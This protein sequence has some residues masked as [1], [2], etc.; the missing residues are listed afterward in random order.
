MPHFIRSIVS[1]SPLLLFDET[2]H[3]ASLVGEL[4]SGE[5]KTYQFNQYLQV[6][7]LQ[8]RFKP[9][10]EIGLTAGVTGRQGMLIPPRHLIPPL[11]NSEVSVCPFSD[12]YFLQ[13][14]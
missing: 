8:Y 1:F 5:N 11:I 14:L 3:C 6:L 4:E 13:D 9:N 12:L 10:L 2:L 7:D